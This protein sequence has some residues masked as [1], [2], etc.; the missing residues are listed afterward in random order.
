MALCIPL[1]SIEFLCYLRPG[2]FLAID[3]E[4]VGV[5]LDA[6]ESALARVSIV[7]YHG[8]LQMDEFVRPK[9]RVVDY[10]TEFSGIRPK[11]LVKGIYH[12]YSSSYSRFVSFFRLTSSKVLR[13]HTEASCRLDQG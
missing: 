3:C 1:R 7:N 6:K 9:E 8:A 13:R 10:R 11:D 4:M 2:K 12:R 5:G